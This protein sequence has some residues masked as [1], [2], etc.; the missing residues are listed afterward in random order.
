MRRQARNWETMF[1]KDTSDK[2]LLP[3][4]YKELLKLN[5]KNNKLILKWAK[6]LN[7]SL[8]KDIHRVNK[9]TEMPYI[10][11]HQGSAN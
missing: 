2:T 5:N 1:A 11:C 10:K 7:R 3:K 4:I 6:D 8:T 9:H